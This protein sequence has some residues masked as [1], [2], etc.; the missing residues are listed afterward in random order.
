[1]M[2]NKRTAAAIGA[3]CAAALIALGVVT[4]RQPERGDAATAGA[5]AAAA[6]AP[7]G[8][9]DARGLRKLGDKPYWRSLSPAQQL[10]LQPL[11]AEWDALDSVRKQRWLQLAGRFGAMKPEEQQRMHERMRAW[12]KLT[13]EQRELARETY[14]R[15]R[16]ITPDQKTATWESYLQLPDA[17][18]RELAATRKTP[19]VVPSQTAAKAVTPL[20]QG[21]AACPAGTV[22]NSLSASPPCVSPAP[23]V[24]AATPPAATPPGTPAVPAPQQPQ[25]QEKPDP[26]NWGITPNNA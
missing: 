19:A 8:K 23:S 5:T 18:K 25:Q 17:Q 13:P 15:T 3:A 10:A 21:G 16:K 24:P 12:V 2:A 1:M 20:S 6:P 9:L 7:A 4:H 22:R 26:A 14:A 11:Q